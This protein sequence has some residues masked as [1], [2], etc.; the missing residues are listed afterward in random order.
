MILAALSVGQCFLVCE[1]YVV[2]QSA[3]SDRGRSQD[4]LGFSWC[5]VSVDPQI[6]VSQSPR[7][8]AGAGSLLAVRCP[9]RSKRETRRRPT[10]GTA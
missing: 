3:A 8:G 1:V 10:C 9:T 2:G 7:L 4:S 5:P 6:R